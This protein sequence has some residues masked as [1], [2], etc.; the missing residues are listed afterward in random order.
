MGAI[1]KDDGYRRVRGNY[2]SCRGNVTVGATS[3]ASELGIFATSGGQRRIDDRLP[4]IVVEA[5]HPHHAIDRDVQSPFAPK[6]SGRSAS[7]DRNRTRTC[8]LYGVKPAQRTFRRD[9]KMLSRA[10][11]NAIADHVRFAPNVQ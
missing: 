8:D 3:P 6:H 5:D 4:R 9:P 7:S 11:K 1:W 2:P 10:R